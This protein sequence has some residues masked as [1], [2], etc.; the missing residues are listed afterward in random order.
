MKK[1]MIKIK[2]KKKKHPSLGHVW[3]MS[4]LEFSVQRAKRDSVNGPHEFHGGK[5]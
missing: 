3:E 2:L 1:K 4:L 5:K